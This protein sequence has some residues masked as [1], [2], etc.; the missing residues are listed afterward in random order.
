MTIVINSVQLTAD[1]VDMGAEAEGQDVSFDLTIK[2]EEQVGENEYRPR[3]GR[4]LDIDYTRVL[5][6]LDTYRA[7]GYIE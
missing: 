7:G 6:I 3:G 2:A 5:A 4:W 1:P